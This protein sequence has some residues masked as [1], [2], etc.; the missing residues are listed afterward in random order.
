M[1][2]DQNGSAA[3]QQMA[4]LIDGDNAQSAFTREILAECSKYGRITIR[5][6]YGDWTTPSM[7]GWKETLQENAI[8]PVQQFRNTVGKNATDSMMIIDAMDVLHAGHVGGFCLVTSD[9]DYTRL[10]TRLR[11]SGAFVMGIGRSMTPK[12]FTNACDLFV[13]VENLRPTPEQPAGGANNKP[14][15]PAKAPLTEALPLL[16][17]AFELAVQDDGWA[18]LSSI[19]ASLRSLDPSFDHRTFGCPTLRALVASF[20]AE[21]ELQEEKKPSGNT[22]LSMRVR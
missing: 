6:V 20:P 5:R 1:A 8:Q 10:A 16:Q 7:N 18:F 14:T 13:F 15:V 3:E 17:K 19:G 9:S 2:D 11:E 22:I 21:I 12:S 4:M